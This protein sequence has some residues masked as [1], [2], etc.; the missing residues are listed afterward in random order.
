MSGG[1][2][3]QGILWSY[4]GCGEVRLCAASQS[5][6]LD[7][8][9]EE[10]LPDLYSGSVVTARVSSDP[11]QGSTNRQPSGFLENLGGSLPCLMC[12]DEVHFGKW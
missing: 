7:A 12:L 5:W 2:K 11:P 10:S 3:A 9:F 6:R 4:G 1:R 8:V